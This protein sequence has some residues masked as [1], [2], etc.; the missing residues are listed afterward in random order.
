M[1]LAQHSNVNESSIDEMSSDLI[2]TLQ[3]IATPIYGKRKKKKKKKKHKNKPI[4]Y[5]SECES[6][7]RSL[8]RA[9]R[10]YRKNPLNRGLQEKLYS[11]KK[12]FKQVCKAAERGVRNK[13]TNQLLGIEAK[14]PTEFWKL[15][16]SMKKWGKNETK[17]ENSIPPEEWL[18]YF[19]DLLGKKP[20]TSAHILKELQELENEPA[21]T[22][23][24][25]RI[26]PNEIEKAI[27]R[28]NKKSSPGPDGILCK[29]LFS[30]KKQLLPMLELFCN[31][32]FTHASQPKTQSLNFLK[33][34]YKKGENW[35]PDNYRGIAVGSALGKIFE[36]ILLTRLEKRIEMTHPI[37]PNQI[38]FKKGHRT[39]D[40][41]FVLKSII[42][43]I[44]KS[45]KKKLYV[46]FIDFRKAYD[47]VNRSLLLLRIQRL[48]I[49][50][51]FYRNIKTIYNSISYLVK[52]HGGHLN[53]IPSY[54][55]LKQGGILSSMLFNLYIDHIKDIFD[56]SCD[57]IRLLKDPLSHM[58]YADDLI[59]LSTSEKGLKRCLSKL[60]EFCDK[61]QLE[62]NISK[63]KIMIFN[64]SGRL[65]KGI[66]FEYKEKP[67]EIVQS[68]CYL[69]IDFSSSGTFTLAKNNLMEKAQKAMY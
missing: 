35:N 16:N 46:A 59:L 42:D 29:H 25:F 39:G 19:Q 7:K 48:G 3:F 54:C 24:D 53:A 65:T 68:Y 32:L 8:N 37:S 12:K 31:K 23:M 36:L 27:N 41:I 22:E 61:W 9:E 60:A 40:H 30:C 38:G 56:E 28:L 58:L 18:S 15:V 69:G 67:M 13:L 52:V 49:K 20:E 17:T 43:K 14:N 5:T 6:L 66:R 45:E 26:S 63:S 10:E 51:L 62:I 64:P 1:F 50:G 55:G 4:W 34:A 2:E 21:F 33:P 47:T 57:P 11:A 44:I